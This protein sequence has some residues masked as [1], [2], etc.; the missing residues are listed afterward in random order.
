MVQV[1]SGGVDVGQAARTLGI[2]A[3]AV[4]KRIRRGTLEAYKL[5]GEWRIVLPVGQDGTGETAR[6]AGSPGNV[7]AGQDRAR[8]ALI[9]QLHSEIEFLRR[10]TEHQAGVIAQLTS[11]PELP[12]PQDNP[13]HARSDDSDAVAQPDAVGVPRRRW[14]QFWQVRA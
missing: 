14:W 12:A 1:Q 5:D 2:T 9:A 3:Q 7:P 4:R 11:R 10:L 6:D 13:V 8:D